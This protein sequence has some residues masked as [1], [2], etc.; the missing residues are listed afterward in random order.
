MSIWRCAKP[1]TLPTIQRFEAPWKRRKTRSSAERCSCRRISLWNDRLRIAESVLP[2]WQALDSEARERARGA[3]EIIDENPQR[4]V[5]AAHTTVGC[6]DQML[7]KPAD[8]EDARRMLAT[9]A[10]QTHI[11]YTGVTL[12]R[13][14]PEYV[15][16][17]VATSEVRILPLESRDIDWYVA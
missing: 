10:G 8:A 3:L 11:V 16:T 9:I 2:Q 15:D 17:R 1:S 4:W 14:D 5:V 12:K 7:E 6:G 13:L